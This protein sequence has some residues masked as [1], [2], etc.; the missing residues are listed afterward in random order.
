MLHVEKIIEMFGT[1]KQMAKTLGVDASA[2]A[3]W[4]KRKAIP[5]RQLF[6][7]RNNLKGKNIDFDIDS[8]FLDK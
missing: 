4:K 6:A 1:Q 5:T 2:I 8:I 3:H 7:I